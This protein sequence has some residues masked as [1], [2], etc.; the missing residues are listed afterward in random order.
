MPDRIFDIDTAVAA[1]TLVVTSGGNVG[2]GTATSSS[3][4]HVNST[5][6]NTYIHLPVNNTA[7]ASADCD[8]Q[9]KV[10]RSIVA[11]NVTSTYLYVCSIQ[12]GSTIGWRAIPTGGVE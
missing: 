10:G 6:A 8:N 1:N 5:A 9:A 2:I 3:L 4:L 7:I 12:S 11:F